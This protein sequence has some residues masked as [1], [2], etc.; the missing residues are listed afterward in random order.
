MTVAD[1]S[2]V[3]K[4]PVTIVRHSEGSYVNGR[5]VEGTESSVIIQANVHPFSDYQV[6]LLPEADRTKSWMWLFTADLV[7]SKKEGT[8]GHGADR[9]LWDGEWYE[10]MKTQKFSMG[11]RDHYEAKCARI[12]LTPDAPSS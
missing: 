1:F 8:Q 5:W 12:E 11:V 9:F 2:L 4:T 10:V 3:R 6:Y 7:R